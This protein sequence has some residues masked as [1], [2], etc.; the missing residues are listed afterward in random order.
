MWGAHFP[1]RCLALD[2]VRALVSPAQTY[3]AARCYEGEAYEA[4][5]EEFKRRLA[6]NPRLRGMC[7]DSPDEVEAALAILDKHADSVVTG[8]ASAAFLS[9]AVLQSGRLDVLVVFAAQTRL[10]LIFGLPFVLLGAFIAL[11]CT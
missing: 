3:A 1:V 7:L 9:T 8:A 4:F 5:L 11:M 2:S 10:I 6:R